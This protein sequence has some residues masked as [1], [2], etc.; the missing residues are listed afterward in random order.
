V[1]DELAG[2]VEGLLAH[3]WRSRMTAFVA[4]NVLKSLASG[5]EPA[6]IQGDPFGI[7]EPGLR[8]SL[9]FPPECVP[10]WYNPAWINAHLVLRHKGRNLEALH[11]LEELWWASGHHSIECVPKITPHSLECLYWAELYLY[12][13]WCHHHLSQADHFGEWLRLAG[14]VIGVAWGHDPKVNPA[15]LPAVVR[16]LALQIVVGLT[17]HYKQA[18]NEY[19]VFQSHAMTVQHLFGWEDA[20]EESPIGHR[21][22]LKRDGILVSAPHAHSG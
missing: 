9:K 18:G 10:G 7:E 21:M 16:E 15:D 19:M 4:V 6:D 20:E 1:A 13:A 22:R 11:L 5:Q 8:I 17:L 2:L 12:M 3:E 14:S